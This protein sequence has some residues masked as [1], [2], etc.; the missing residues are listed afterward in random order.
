[1]GLL[2]QG[3]LNITAAQWASEAMDS[4][5]APVQNYLMVNK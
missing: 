2:S 4:P 1:M 5:S 3:L